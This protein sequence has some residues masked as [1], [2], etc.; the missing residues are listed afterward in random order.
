MKKDKS[1][2][3]IYN[4]QYPRGYTL[5][6]LLVG[7]TVISIVFSIGF[8][9]YRQFSRRQALTGVSKNLSADLRLAQQLALTGQKPSGVTCTVL[10]GY[11]F[12]VVSSSTYDLRADCTNNANLPFKTVNLPAGA[13]LTASNT[14]TLFKV[15]GQGTNLTSNNVLRITSSGSSTAA[16]ITVGTGGNIIVESTSVPTTGPAPTASPAPSGAPTATPGGTP[17]CTVT[18]VSSTYSLTVGQTI[19]IAPTIT[20]TNGGVIQQ[21]R[22]IPTTTYFTVCNS[23]ITPC[24]AGTGVYDDTTSPYSAHLTAQAVTTTPVGLSVRGILT[25]GQTCNATSNITVTAGG[26][27]PAP[28]A[29]PSGCVNL[30]F[31]SGNASPSTVVRGGSFTV[32]CNYGAQTNGL[33]YS[34]AAGNCTWSGWSGTT[35]IFN[36]IA[37]NTV[38]T[39][40]VSC[41]IITPNSGNY[42]IRTDPINS[43]T[44]Q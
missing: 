43:V 34:S 6:E 36:C 11:A 14:R 1:Q 27:T 32:S 4:I 16:Q 5:I 24:P 18:G 44:V 30:N 38:G 31:I 3:T 15:L 8:A 13:A 35:G 28:T 33:A 12:V 25:T 20:G 39:H 23:T 22:F 19:T 41:R 40:A 37:G 7:I 26:A 21:G 42:C 10:N 17:G 2:Y 9:G 29:S